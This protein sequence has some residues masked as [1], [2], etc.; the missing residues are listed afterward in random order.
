[1]GTFTP[2]IAP[3]VSRADPWSG[4]AR[5]RLFKYFGSQDTGVTVWQDQDLQWHE[6][7]YPYAGRPDV[8]GLLQARRAYQGGHIH[9]ITDT[10]LVELAGV[11]GKDYFSRINIEDVE[12]PGWKQEHLNKL[13]HWRISTPG[14]GA[15]PKPPFIN[16]NEQ[17]VFQ[18]LSGP[19]GTSGGQRDVWLHDDVLYENFEV[20]TYMD[21][22]RYGE[23]AG[24]DQ[25]LQQLGIVLRHNTTAGEQRMV[26][27]NN[28]VFFVVP[29]LNIGVWKSAL[30]GS[31][32]GNRQ[33]SLMDFTTLFNPHFPYELGIR[34]DDNVVRCRVRKPNT[35]WP[36]WVDT[37]NAHTYSTA[38][39]LDTECGSPAE[40][41]SIPTPVDRGS[42]GII[43][44]HLG[45]VPEG[46]F[47]RTVIRNRSHPDRPAS[48]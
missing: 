22:P 34:L 36:P 2:P 5:D 10:Q 31:S 26:A 29:V 17:A 25:Y 33:T 46:I 19:Q 12:I 27:I 40:V 6:E 13:N 32:M 41:A 42:C 18:N 23:G 14:D 7:Q 20:E 45:Q 24:P 1:M 48:P 37:L 43:A 9:D 28:N 4:R 38:V 39:N 15:L 11:P 21:A 44:N 8:P 16:Q 35:A 3:G 30:D 47:G